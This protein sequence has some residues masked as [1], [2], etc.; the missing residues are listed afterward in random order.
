MKT[1][2]DCIPCLFR[3]A[4]NTARAATDDVRL[5]AA[6]LKEV[7][8]RVERLSLDNTPA[9]VSKTAYEVV[10]EVTGIADP[11]KKSKE[12]TNAEALRILPELEKI[13]ARFRY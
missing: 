13:V 4:L 5:H 9:G 6:V 7:S 11:F 1:Y 10:S 3:Q 8:R 12:R 2:P